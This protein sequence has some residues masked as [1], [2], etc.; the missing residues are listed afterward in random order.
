MMAVGLTDSMDSAMHSSSNAKLPRGLRRVTRPD[1]LRVEIAESIKLH[2]VSGELSFGTHLVETE[3]ALA[4]GVSR[5][6]VREALQ[7]LAQDG[8]VDL[9]RG[10]GAFVHAPTVKEVEEVFGVRTVLEAEAAKQA[11]LKVAEGKIDPERLEQLTKIFREGQAEALSGDGIKIVDKN[12]EL[13][14][15]IVQLPGNSV[16][17]EM[18][19]LIEE[20]VRWFF[21]AIAITR[22]PASWEEHALVVEAILEGKADRAYELMAEYCDRSRLGLVDLS[23]SGFLGN[24]DAERSGN[25]Q[26]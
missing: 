25:T 11:A 15:A 17:A 12:A 13:H 26:K 8:W 10:L 16:L 20:R 23:Y 6:P 3:L 21:G 19:A 2:I 7:L 9:R 4:L 5:L 18:A 22:A 24:D 1:P 14:S